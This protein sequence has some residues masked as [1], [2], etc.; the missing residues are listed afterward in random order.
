MSKPSLTIRFKAA[1]SKSSVQDPKS[2]Q[3]I[4]KQRRLLPPPSDST[5]KRSTHEVAAAKSAQGSSAATCAMD[6]S[7]TKPELLMV[8]DEAVKEKMNELTSGTT[9]SQA[10]SD[11][12]KLKSSSS[13]AVEKTT[14]KKRKRDK[15]SERDVVASSHEDVKAGHIELKA[16]GTGFDCLA[17]GSFLKTRRPFSSY[18]LV[19]Q[20]CNSLK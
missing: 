4:V 2:K 6:M 7:I 1:S 16:N 5:S 12:S 14:T 17:C 9:C 15:R 18:N 8:I 20:S 10:P 11:T 19:E 13:A 3:K